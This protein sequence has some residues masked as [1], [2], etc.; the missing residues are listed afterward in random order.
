MGIP[1]NSGKMLTRHFLWKEEAWGGLRGGRASWE[2]GGLQVTDTEQETR[3]G[4]DGSWRR[5]IQSLGSRQRPPGSPHREHL[6]NYVHL[7]QIQILYARHCTRHC[8]R[9]GG[10]GTQSDKAPDDGMGRK[11]QSCLT[12]QWGL[13]SPL[14]TEEGQVTSA[15]ASGTRLALCGT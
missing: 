4:G 11:N 7:L 15:P 5:R 10:G 9:H 12:A 3:S 2:A 1:F 14:N 6:R 8:R 13:V